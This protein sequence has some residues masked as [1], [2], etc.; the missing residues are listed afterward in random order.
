MKI[1]LLPSTIDENGMASDRQHLLTMIVDDIVAV[2]A[3]CL[4]LSCSRAQRESVRDILL[5]HTHLDHIAG[6][7]LFIDDLFASLK[8]PIRIHV[9]REIK[10]I[11][12][13]DVFNWSIY[14]RFSELSNDFGPVIEYREIESDRPFD[15]QHL[16]I[17]I[18]PVNH[19]VSAVGFFIADPRSTIAITGDTAETDE[20]W[21]RCNEAESMRAVLVECAF[22]DELEELAI[23]SNHLTP[24]RLRRELEKLNDKDLPVY[25]INIKPMYR[26]KVIE[27]VKEARMTGVEIMRIGQV[28]EF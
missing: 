5:S 18:I 8:E 3:G 26:E 17:N 28:Y 19:K 23:A 27:Q 25:L 21:Q 14:P 22:P 6:L 12:E 13:R 20:F 7:P 16:S 2:D 15:I 11:L 24:L 10:E 4:A 1:Q 9:T